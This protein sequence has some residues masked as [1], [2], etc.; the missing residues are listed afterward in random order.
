MSPQSGRFTIT[1]LF[2]PLTNAKAICIIILITCV[3][4]G[5][6]LFNNFA[7]DDM[8]YIIDNTQIH[9]WSLSHIL[10]PSNFNDIHNDYY[11][12]IPALY[13][14]LAYLLFH[15][16]FLFYHLAQIALQ[17]AVVVLIYFLF[18]KFMKK[19]LSLFLSLI[20]LVHP[21]QVE[22]VSFIAQTVSPLFVL[23]GLLA[24]LLSTK[25]TI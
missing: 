18:S 17:S 11:W 23:F 9:M 10:G 3:V 15:E 4:Y 14:T 8:S 1:A 22:S 2:N 25:T 12:P 7:F 19:H 24:L 13:F 21:M 5:N 20:F 16:N 6:S